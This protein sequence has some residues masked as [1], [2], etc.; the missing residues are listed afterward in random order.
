[1][2]ICLCV[3]IVAAASQLVFAGMRGVYAAQDLGV[4]DIVVSVPDR[5]VLMPHNCRYAGKQQCL[6]DYAI[7]SCGHAYLLVVPEAFSKAVGPF[8]LLSFCLIP[9]TYQDAL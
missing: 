4:G 8:S 5:I 6:H 7:G 2:A 3:K 1:M 9:E